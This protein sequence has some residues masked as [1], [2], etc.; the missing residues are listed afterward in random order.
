MTG[1]DKLIEREDNWETDMGAWFAGERVVFRGL[2]VFTE[3]FD[4]DWVDI[5]FFSITGKFFTKKQIEL[6]SRTWTLSSSYPEPRIW[7]NRVAAL[8]GSAR[9]TAMISVASAIAISEAKV[10]AGQ[11]NLVAADFI[12]RAKK[13]VVDEGR[14][15][16]DVVKQEMK[17][18]RQ[19]P[20]GFG[21]PIINK[22]ER[23]PVALKLA[24]E[25]G[26]A[27]GPH[28]KLAFEIEKLLSEK[29]YRAK[30]NILGFTSAMCA[31]QGLTPTEFYRMATIIYSAGM[32]ACYIDAVDKPAG[33]FF[34]L[35][36]E[37]ISYEGKP[38]RKWE[39]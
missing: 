33:T 5:W 25:L 22:D 2:D 4:K 39:N 34:P 29:R 23:V 32:M 7:N 31:D 28:V 24:K 35:R 9:T 18:I 37:R 8:S 20:F 14:D 16:F 11:A 27:D 6:F 19:I 36:C 1:P 12:T 30:L 13:L 38:H 17:L 26:F 21:R 15:L 10:Y 3:L